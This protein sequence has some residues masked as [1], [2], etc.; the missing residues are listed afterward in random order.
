M[1][2]KA[3]RDRRYRIVDTRYTNAS[4]RAE[5]EATLNDLAEDGYRIIHITP[6]GPSSLGGL[7]TYQW[8]VIYTLELLASPEPIF[9]DEVIPPI[10]T[11]IS[12]N[13]C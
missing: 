5:L 13:D 8:E 3:K 6:I 7:S 10:E 11:E 4:K 2:N 12:S 1:S 9:E